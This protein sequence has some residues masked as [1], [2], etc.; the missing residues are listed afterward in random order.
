M[1][2]REKVLWVSA[3]AVLVIWGSYF[4]K[5]VASLRSGPADASDA[6]GGFIGSVIMLVIVQVAAVIV[7]AIASPGE[8]NAPPDD[9][10]R[11][12]DIGAGRPAYVTLSVLIVV[13]MLATP[14]IIP[15]A[16][17]LVSGDPAVVAGL[18]IGNALLFA[19]VMAEL[20]HSGWQIV[21]YRR[22]S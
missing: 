3:T 15:V 13:I 17:T 12:F 9:R 21:C 6:I 22:G 19:L 8:A 7:L 1:S 14:L 16:P 4:L 2:F 10:E 5:L 20:V 11:A 18:V